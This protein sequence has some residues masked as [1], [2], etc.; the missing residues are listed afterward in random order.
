MTGSFP[1]AFV[2]FFCFVSPSLLLC[3]KRCSFRLP[4]KKRGI[5]YGLLKKNRKAYSRSHLYGNKCPVT[6]P[7]K[8]FNVC[9]LPIN[10]PYNLRVYY[11]IN[12]FQNVFERFFASG[13]CLSSCSV[14]DIYVESF[15]KNCSMVRKKSGHSELLLLF[16][17]VEAVVVTL[18]NLNR[19]IQQIEQW[20]ISVFFKS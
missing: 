4:C 9:T 15:H 11:G 12:D 10:Q 19:S 20:A 18:I 2:R 8:T 13:E 17:V 7:L 1:A 16:A 5:T 6:L 14:L 3:E